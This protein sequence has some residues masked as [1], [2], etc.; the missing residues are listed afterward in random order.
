VQNHAN[1]QWDLDEINQRL[2]KR[3]FMVMDL[4]FSRWQSFVVGEAQSTDE[5][6]EN[7]DD[8]KPGFRC[9]ALSIAIERVAKA[10]LMR[11]IWP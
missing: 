3:M 11:G 10:T 7:M 4:V 2:E 8:N 9:I 1:Q 6:P 5:K